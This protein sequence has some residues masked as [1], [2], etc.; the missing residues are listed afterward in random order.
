[1]SQVRLILF[2]A[3]FLHTSLTTA[4]LVAVLVFHLLRVRIGYSQPRSSSLPMS[5]E[6]LSNCELFCVLSI[7]LLRTGEAMIFDALRDCLPIGAEIHQRF[8][9]S[10]L[11]SGRHLH[12]RAELRPCA[13]SGEDPQTS[14]SGRQ[15]TCSMCHEM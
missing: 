6:L 11:S 7:Q 14:D 10:A 5:F 12:R 4:I 3:P 2:P 8:F 1:M 9:P 15:V 13:R